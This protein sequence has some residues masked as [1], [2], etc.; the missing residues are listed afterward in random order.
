MPTNAEMKSLVPPAVLEVCQTLRDAGYEA[1]VV[2]GAVRDLLLGK[3]PSDWDVASDGL[4]EKVLTL[5]ERTIATGLQHGTITAVVGRGKAREN[6]EITT[7][8]GEGAY[9]DARRPDS[10][11]FGVPLDEDLKRRDFVINAMA[12]DPVEAKVHDPFGGAQDLENKLVRAVGVASERFNED[13]LR[14]MRAVRFVSTLDFELEADTEKAL[15]SALEALSRVAQ[16]RVRV[17]LLKLLGGVAPEV[18]LQ[19]A[20][21]NGVLRVIL[22]ELT[23]PLCAAAFSRV[24]ACEAD[25]VLRLGALLADLETEKLEP[26]LRRLRASNEDRQ[27]V[28]AMLGHHGG[29]AAAGDDEVKMRQHLSEVGRKAGLDHLEV[30][31]AEAAR[32]SNAQDLE[33]VKK[34]RLLLKESIPLEVGDLAINGSRVMAITGARGRQIGEILRALLARVLEEPGFNTRQNLEALATELADVSPE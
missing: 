15:S 16:E 3:L 34:A 13:G 25:P 6:V 7:F 21:R 18:A 30:M 24:L 11:H 28:I 4:P 22:P 23:E 9:S 33:R 5:F 1:W 27:R 12:F 26:I 14:V 17:E 10:V 29:L 19:I 32:S 2:G 8:R 31:R 20:E